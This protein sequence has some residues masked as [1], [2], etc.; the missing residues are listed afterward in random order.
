MTP[1][2]QLLV[3]L[4]CHIS[5]EPEDGY[6]EDEKDDIKIDSWQTLIHDLNP[7]EKVMVKEAMQHKLTQLKA[8]ARVSD[9][10]VDL[11]AIID[12]YLKDELQ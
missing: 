1:F 4:M 9:E 11:M 2:T 6:S 3:A 7:S 10:Q 12:A 8:L 5:A